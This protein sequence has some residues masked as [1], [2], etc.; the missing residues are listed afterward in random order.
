[1]GDLTKK[2]IHHGCGGWKCRIV[3]LAVLGSRE[4]LSLPCRCSS[5]CCVFTW[6]FL[7]VLPSLGFLLLTRAQVLLDQALPGWSH[8]A[9]TTSLKARLLTQSHAVGKGAGLPH[10]NS[11]GDTSQPIQLL[12]EIFF[13][14]VA[15]KKKIFIWFTLC[16]KKKYTF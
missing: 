11:G 16:S 5:L 1:M 12:I 13:K 8:L 15:R 7:C 9:L 14:S 6:P 3:G 10:M 4:A 2:S